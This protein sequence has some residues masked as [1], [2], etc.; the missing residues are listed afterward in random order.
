FAFLMVA[1]GVMI[2]RK[3]QPNRPRPFRTPLVWVVCPLA[4]AGTLLLFFNLSTYT[5]AMF[6]GW[7]AIGIIFYYAYGYRRSHLAN[8]TEAAN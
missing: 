6:F 3:T 2:L 7:S 4:I 8:G 1:V 5:L